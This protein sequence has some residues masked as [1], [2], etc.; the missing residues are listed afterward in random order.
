MESVPPDYFFG[1][2]AWADY[3]NDGALDLYVT[4]GY[5]GTYPDPLMLPLA[6]LYHNSG[7]GTFTKVTDSTVADDPTDGGF[8]SWVDYD[9]DGFMDL[10]VGKAPFNSPPTPNKLYHN[11]GNANAWLNVKLVGTATNRS[12]IGAKVRVKAFYRGASRWQLREISGGDSNDNQQSLNAEFG[13]ADATIIETVRV[14]WPS[15]M[16][17]ELHDV[18]PRQFL[19][20][21]ETA[22]PEPGFALSLVSGLALV[23]GLRLRRK[24]RSR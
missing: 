6:F 7:D 11:D 14:K 9:N 1:G 20:I 17:Q 23:T 19:T 3:D 5:N 8:P 10:F 13:L 12:A 16:V 24:Q 15:G 22:V 18:A 4:A 21:T 2:C